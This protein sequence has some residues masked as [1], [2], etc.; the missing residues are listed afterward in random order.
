MYYLKKEITISGAH[1]LN[2]DYDSKCKNLHGHN[3]KIVVYLKTDK[4]NKKC[5]DC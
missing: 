4:L 3:W 2:L 1:C 5:A